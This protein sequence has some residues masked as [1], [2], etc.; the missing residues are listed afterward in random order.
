MADFVSS[1]ARLSDPSGCLKDNPR[2]LKDCQEKISSTLTRLFRQPENGGNP[3]LFALSGPKPHI[4]ARDLPGGRPFKT[5]A[6]DGKTYFWHPEFLE[7][8][9]ADQAATVMSHESYHDLFYHCSPERAAGM[10]PDDWNVSVDYVVNGVIEADHDKSG[11][12]R[13]QPALWGGPLGDPIPYD[14]YIEWIDGKRDLAEKGCFADATVHGR[15]PESMYD[16]IRKHKLNSPRRCKEHSGGCGA[17]TIDP[18]TGLSTITLPWAP[19]ACQKCGAKPG[20]GRGPGSLDAHMPNRRTKDEVMGDMMRAA[21]QVRAMGRGDVPGDIE[22]ALGRLNKPELSVRDII[23]CALAQKQ[24]DAGNVNDWKRI[25]RRPTFIHVKDPA[26]GKWEPKHRLYIPKKHDFRAQIAVMV[27][28]SGSMSNEDMAL[29]VKEISVVAHVAEIHMTP[30]DTVPH[31]KKTLK[32]TNKNDLKDF[33]AAGRGGTDFAQ[34][35]TELPGQSWY[36]GCDLVII[37]TDGDCGTYPK[38]LLPKN[39]DLLW[40]LTNQREFHPT[41]G[42]V[43]KL[44]PS[45]A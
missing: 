44:R 37:I 21:D 25:R 34:Y 22:E 27:D 32:V 16:E 5:A 31:W 29:G 23:K 26:T 10:D 2:L 43:V 19:E 3:F 9:N 20:E 41:G 35:L 8:L 15:S 38:N 40:I 39:A 33:V 28:T 24:I 14:H 1:I 13:R 6:T 42:R 30:N 36:K 17:M 12:R 45:H 7:S 11:R 18:K 4:V